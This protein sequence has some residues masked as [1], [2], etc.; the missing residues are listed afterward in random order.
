M[1]EKKNTEFLFEGLPMINTKRFVPCKAIVYGANGIG[2]S[3]LGCRA[4][5]PILMD[6]EGNANHL[7]V[8][9]PKNKINSFEQARSFINT[10]IIKD[11]NFNTLIVDSAD[12]LE[13]FMTEKMYDESKDPIKDLAFGGSAKL[14]IKYTGEFMGA[15]ETLYTKKNMNII[16]VAHEK[17]KP[18]NDPMVEPHD[19]YVLKINESMKSIFCNW[20]Q[21]VF[22]IK[23]E[24]V[25]E[26]KDRGSFGKKRAK[27]VDRR[28]IY[29]SPTPTHYA[30]N[31]FNLPHKILYEKDKGWDTIVGHIKNYYNEERKE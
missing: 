12:S 4:K 16:I 21:C 26:E 25:L 23:Q 11:H 15:L 9:R 27:E 24:V 3:S 28:I 29:T 30:K 6:M 7:D 1:E 31:T 22:F 17:I 10:L 19:R 20:V 18:A 5:N 8:A 13:T 2:K 14:Y